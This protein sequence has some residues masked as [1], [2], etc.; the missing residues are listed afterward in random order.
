MLTVN[1]LIGFGFSKVPVTSLSFISSASTMASNAVT[2]PACIAGDLLIYIAHT[3]S[4]ASGLFGGTPSGFTTISQTGNGAG[5][6]AS[7]GGS[8]KI[9]DGTEGS[10]TYG[11]TET[12]R[13]RQI[14]VF[15]GDVP[16]SSVTQLYG[17]SQDAT[18]APSSMTTTGVS[19]S[20]SLVVGSI[21]DSD[22]SSVP[23]FTTESPALGGYVTDSGSTAGVR[24]GYKIYNS[25][26][27]DHTIA[28]ADLGAYNG[29]FLGAISVS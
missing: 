4:L 29:I 25:S 6:S 1:Q 24:T 8:Y 5:P 10:I 22:T 9:A 26:P 17:N 21:F 2:C 28:M 20:P 27:A 14:L 19:V 15:R 11:Y 13:N 12:S 16:I 3:Y 18:G 7:T 23:A